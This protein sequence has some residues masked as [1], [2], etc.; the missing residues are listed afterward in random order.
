MVIGNSEHAVLACEHAE[1]EK[2]EQHRRA[3]APRDQPREDAQEPEH[4]DEFM[5]VRNRSVAEGDELSAGH[6]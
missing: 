3:D 4:A 6:A 5:R 1:S 2:N